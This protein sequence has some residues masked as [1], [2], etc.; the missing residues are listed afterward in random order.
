VKFNLVA[1]GDYSQ[2]F[3]FRVGCGL[4]GR[5]YQSGLPTWEQGVQNAPHNHFER[6]G[7]ASQWGI[8]TVVGIPVASPKVGRV[9]VVLY[10]CHDRQQDQDLVSKLMDEFTRVCLTFVIILMN[11]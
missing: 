10:S 1:F 5:V 9:V 8:K 3:S 2:K 6:C 11:A 4:P 7:G